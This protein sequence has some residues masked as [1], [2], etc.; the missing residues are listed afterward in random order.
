MEYLLNSDKRRVP[1]LKLAIEQAVVRYQKQA[2]EHT[3]RFE[4]L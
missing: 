4:Q 2:L 3:L 1:E